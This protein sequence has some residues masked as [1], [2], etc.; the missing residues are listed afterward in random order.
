MSMLQQPKIYF[1]ERPKAL[2]CNR[3]TQA[4]IARL[5]EDT[6]FEIVDTV[7]EAD[8][9][10]FGGGADVTPSLYGERPIPETGRSDLTRDYYEQEVFHN[11]FDL[12]KPMFGICRGAQFLHVMCGGTLW[13]DVNGHC[14]THMLL[15]SITGETLLTSST[16]HQMMKWNKDMMVLAT[17]PHPIAT[18]MK[19]ADGIIDPQATKEMEV[20]ACMYVEHSVLCI[21]GHPEYGPDKFTDWSLSTLRDFYDFTRKSKIPTNLN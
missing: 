12:E 16:H 11:A 6:G 8:L 20:E 7:P 10:V 19:N 21:Q 4:L 14:G 15:D 1:P 17:V 9:V 2:V 13:Q 18:Y 5:L 3:P